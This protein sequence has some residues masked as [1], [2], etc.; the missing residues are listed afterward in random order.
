MGIWVTFFVFLF[1]PVLKFLEVPQTICVI[2]Y[3]Y[4]HFQ[5]GGKKTVIIIIGITIIIISI[6][7]NKIR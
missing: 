1:F 7:A 2:K 5:R 3:S 4:F 6:I